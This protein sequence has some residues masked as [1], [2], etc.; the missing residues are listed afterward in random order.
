MNDLKNILKSG[1][2]LMYGYNNENLPD[3]INVQDERL[4]IYSKNPK[5][6][7]GKG[8]E[9]F[10]RKYHNIQEISRGRSNV[11]FLDNEA[12]KGTVV[13]YPLDC[14]N[15][16]VALDVP[17][18]WIMLFIGILRRVL[19]GHVKIK[20]IV[21]LKTK[22]NSRV[23]L[24][25]KTLQKRS[26][27]DFYFSSEIGIQGM[28][29]YLKQNKI[30]YVV[31][32][33]YQK[34]P[35][36]YTKGSDIDIL[37]S[38][39]DEEKLKNY[40][41]QNPGNIKVDIWNESAPSYSGVSYFI[42]RLAKQILKSSIA[43]PGG[44]RIPGKKEALLS[45]LYHT[46]YHKGINAGIISKTAGVESIDNPD[47]K[48]IFE[49]QN[50]SRELKV[51]VGSTMEEMDDYLNTEGWKPKIDTLA[52]I[53]QWNEW[54]RV[55]HFSNPISN[56]NSIS[57]FILRELAI[58]NNIVGP[59]KDLIRKEGFEIVTDIYLK[60]EV[61]AEAIKHLRGGTWKDAMYKDNSRE[62]E[63]AFAIVILDSHVNN[64][65]RFVSLKEKIRNKFDHDK[66][67][68]IVHSTDNEIESWDYINCCFPGMEKEIKKSIQKLE[69]KKIFIPFYLKFTKFLP[70]YKASLN[71]K[72]KSWI[73]NMV[74]K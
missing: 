42:P 70:Y 43:G 9:N 16:L 69:E 36:L 66:S 39:Q 35:D 46:L 30:N 26:G 61:R 7:N 50:L 2:I 71:S 62:F 51:N 24:Y 12:I 23:W 5:K 34:L 8:Y 15:V 63:P 27:N 32:R 59:I 68:S 17:K 33:F 38:N 21:R 64:L 67:P 11:V 65:N 60:E 53:A 29:D 52:K 40:L 3:N 72:I 54:V 10:V 37:V 55:K 18:Y 49:I 14:Q 41:I 56:Y 48:Y 1:R 45:L 20:G 31:M 4:C 25:L 6:L 47:N 44:S 74:T 28:L 58:T 19:L 22:N 13:G 57:V 73:L